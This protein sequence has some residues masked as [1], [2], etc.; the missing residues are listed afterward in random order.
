[1]IARK[2]TSLEQRGVDRLTDEFMFFVP[3]IPLVVCPQAPDVVAEYCDKNNTNI[4][5]VGF[6]F[7]RQLVPQLRSVIPTHCVFAIRNEEGQKFFNF[8]KGVIVDDPIERKYCRIVLN[9]VKLFSPNAR[10]GSS[11][12]RLESKAVQVISMSIQTMDTF[13]FLS[14]QVNGYTDLTFCRRREIDTEIAE[15]MRSYRGYTKTKRS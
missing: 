9:K 12:E 14:Q 8:A 10:T 4:E 7:E 5:L 6:D 3:Y 15:L 2:A 11:Q 13:Y 1:M